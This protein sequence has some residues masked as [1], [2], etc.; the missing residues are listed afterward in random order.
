MQQYPAG[1]QIKY[2]GLTSAA[3]YDIELNV[4]KI[5]NEFHD[6][7]FSST[8]HADEETYT[9]SLNSQESN[10]IIYPFS[11]MSFAKIIIMQGSREEKQTYMRTVFFT[12]SLSSIG[13]LFLSAYSILGGILRSYET[14][15]VKKSLI[16][17]V[18][19]D[20]DVDRDS[21]GDVT[22]S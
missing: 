2:V 7:F 6:N 21:V 15:S 16:K 22:D 14:F 10:P 11:T 5:S 4:Q 19:A 13:A 17:R 20:A 1:G 12:D 3:T 8:D 9:Y 18:Y